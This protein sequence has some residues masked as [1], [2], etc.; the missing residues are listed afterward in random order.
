[1]EENHPGISDEEMDRIRRQAMDFSGIGLYR[2]RLDGTIAFLDKGAL[3]ILD[4]E[5]RYPDPSVLVGRNLSSLLEYKLP[6][7]F[8]RKR[9]FEEKH[10]RNL[11]YPFRTLSGKDR[12]ALHDSYLIVDRDTGEEMV[13]VIVRDVTEIKMAEEAL[14]AERERLAV[15]LRCIGDGVISTDAQGSIQ[16]LN[17]KAE[18]LTGWPQ[19]VARGLPLLQVF[20]MVDERTRE[21]IENPVEKIL[22]SGGPVGLADPAILISRDGQERR[23]AD[24]GAPILDRD[25][26]LVGA[27]LVFRDI[28]ALVEAQR[29][30]EKIA[31]LESLGLL[32][33]GIAHDFN[34]I[35]TAILGNISLVRMCAG[36]GGDKAPEYLGQA[37]R[38]VRQARS[39]TLQL[40]TF[41]KG[42][43]PLREPLS[44]E[45]LLRDTT[46]FVL[47]GSIVEPFFQIAEDLWHV[48]ADPAQLSQVITNIVINAKQAMPDGGKLRISADNVAAGG[49]SHP[50]LDSGK[51]YVRLRFQDEGTGIP[52]RHL[53]RIFDPYFTTKQ[54]GTG[55]GLASAFSIVRRHDGHILADSTP[56]TG[57]TLTVF[58]CASARKQTAPVRAAVRAKSGTGRILVMDDE[59]SVRNACAAM[60]EN[61]GYESVCVKNGEEASQVFEASLTSGRKFEGVILDLTIR[62]GMG[63]VATIRRLRELDPG[64]VAI[65]SSGYSTDVVLS[66]YASY[67]FRGFVAQPYTMEQLSDVLSRVLA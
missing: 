38:A 25:Q 24:S 36:E 20:R 21:P 55:L 51:R 47:R 59:D 40:L 5:D 61:L 4:L 41:S 48:E 32:A 60:L 46:N 50:V 7:G 62:G 34:N 27:V 19:D 14:D 30:R 64:V 42:G 65:V 56:G 37:E 43:E 58:L 18:L 39:L 54:E 67:G 57:T 44:L 26:R 23:I 2:Y 66:E 16:F 1:M 22:A 63:G 31:R 17:Q 49:G 15:T 6:V 29:E 45:V 11:Q 33:G 3:R 53:S 13:Q 52:A 12:W 28:T 10:V 9:I 8:L 35:L